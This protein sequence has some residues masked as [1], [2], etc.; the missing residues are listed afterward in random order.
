MGVGEGIRGL[1]G[2]KKNTL[3]VVLDSKYGRQ[4]E[5]YGHSEQL[6]ERG[7]S[8]WSVFNGVAR[9]DKSN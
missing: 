7:C 4:M 6:L 2:F 9:G 3:P 8:F 1:K 5:G